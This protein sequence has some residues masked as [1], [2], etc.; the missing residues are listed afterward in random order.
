MSEKKYCRCP[1]ERAL[2]GREMPC[3]RAG[4]RAWMLP[5]TG[6]SFKALKASLQLGSERAKKALSELQGFLQTCLAVQAYQYVA[7]SFK[8][9][10]LGPASTDVEW[11][12]CHWLI[13]ESDLA[14]EPSQ[15]VI[16]RAEAILYHLSY[17]ICEH[18][19][20]KILLADYRTGT[21]PELGLSGL[22]SESNRSHTKS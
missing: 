17:V 21:D 19:A 22:K 9:A 18:L 1:P 15:W 7:L 14:F 12:P 6:V 16:C 11:D 13:L 20:I 3:Q 8:L 4:C 5:L 10:R 2:S